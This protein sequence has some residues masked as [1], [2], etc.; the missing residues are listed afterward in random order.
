MLKSK[1]K[2]FCFL[3]QDITSFV[4]TINFLE[5]A[6]SIYIFI[7]Q[8]LHYENIIRKACKEGKTRKCQQQLPAFMSLDKRFLE[9][10]IYSECC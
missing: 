8:V 3:L 4:K 2:Q 1:R 7:S 6:F 9:L 5:S 10:N